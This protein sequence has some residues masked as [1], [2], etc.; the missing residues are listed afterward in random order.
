MPTL[1]NFKYKYLQ[2]LSDGN[3]I[4]TRWSS[5]KSVIQQNL[6][7]VNNWGTNAFDLG[8]KLSDIFISTYTTGRV[9][10]L[11]HQQEMRGS[12]SLHGI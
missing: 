10:V 2:H 8:D 6:S 5:W 7:S 12:V 9:K 11:F 1:N 4:S 3:S